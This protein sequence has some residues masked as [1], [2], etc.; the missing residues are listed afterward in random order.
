MSSFTAENTEYDD[1]FA[2]LLSAETFVDLDKLRDVAR[3][4]IPQVYRG[5]VWKYLLGIASPD[6]SEEITKTKRLR[7]SYGHSSSSSSSSSTA[8]METRHSSMLKNL[9][10][11][12][13]AEIQQLSMLNNHRLESMSAAHDGYETYIQAHVR[14][15]TGQ[16]PQRLKSYKITRRKR[17]QFENVLIAFLNYNDTVIEFDS[18]L[19]CMLAPFVISMDEEYVMYYCFRSFMNHVMGQYQIGQ[20]LH[21]EL[22][23]L[24]MLFRCTQPELYQ[25]F[26]REELEPNEWALPWIRY[27]LSKELPLACVC[28]LWDTYFATNDPDLHC[29]ICLSILQFHT[30]TLMEY[31]YSEMMFFL[32]HLPDMDM[33]AIIK[34]AYNI[35][36]YVKA[37]ELL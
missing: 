22:G 30:E 12:V 4:G 13:H 32:R 8:A 23:K 24:M 3:H 26:E 25:Y 29:Y 33:D 16:L 5:E 15:E 2:E 9:V 34:Q 1:E 17:E 14:T 37:Q 21:W 18:G 35:R 20:R 7:S 28:R 11:N 31:E 36:A 19:M 10:K 6:K 27:Q